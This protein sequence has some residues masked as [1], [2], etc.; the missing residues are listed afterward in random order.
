LIS[1]NYRV[2]ALVQRRPYCV[3]IAALADK[4]ARTARAVPGKG[5]P[6]DQAKWSPGEMA[7]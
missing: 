5:K 7:A 1:E 3:V 4:L 6:F 2:T